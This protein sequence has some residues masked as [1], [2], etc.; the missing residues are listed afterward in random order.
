MSNQVATR[1][2][3]ND[4]RLVIQNPKIQEQLIAALPRH[5][6]P[7]QFTVIVRTAIN[8]NPKLAE[9]D[10]SSFLAAMLTAAQMGLAPDGRNGH[11]IP[12]YNGKTQ[13][14]EAAFQPDYKGLVKLVRMN[15][16]VSTVY[17]EAVHENDHFQIKK[18]L[19]RD[20]VHDID[21]RSPRGEF[22]GAYAVIS[23][24]D[25]SADFD[26]MS[27][28]EIDAIRKRSQSPNAGPWQ[29]DY[30]EMAK[31][32]II[33]RLLKLA[34]LSPE[35][36][37]RIS[38]DPEN[39]ISITEAPTPASRRPEL[40]EAPQRPSLPQVSQQDEP[41]ES[42]DAEWSNAE[43]AGDQ[44]P[45]PTQHDEPALELLPKAAQP[46]KKATL[47]EKPKAAVAKPAPEKKLPLDEI[48]H[49]LAE[50][51]QGDE[52]L[53]TILVR[54]NWVKPGTKLDELSQKIQENTLTYW[55]EIVGELS[56]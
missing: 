16:N 51:G 48:R 14:M 37:E 23:Y 26:F 15:E 4:L 39:S 52:A 36:A 10:Q 9:C 33:K 5:Y 28:E 55:D 45:L 40:P 34:D 11:L 19:H 21:I 7:D 1:G 44:A 50:M 54:E 35:T 3:S 25:G 46:Q 42:A 20:L 24:K 53:L 30:I 17:A 31:K 32:T 49:R 43:D 47:A 18:G 38:H 6:T 12:R 29:T 41:A 13:R 56:K 27:K 22:L 8:K 2:E